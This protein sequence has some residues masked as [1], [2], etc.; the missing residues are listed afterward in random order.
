MNIGVIFR[1]TVT[2]ESGILAQLH[3]CQS[4]KRQVRRF[5]QVPISASVQYNKVST[6]YELT[7]SFNLVI[8]LSFLEQLSPLPQ[9][10]Q[11]QCRFSY[12]MVPSHSMTDLFLLYPLPYLP[13]A[14][15][16][17]HFL[18]PPKKTGSLKKTSLMKRHMATATHADHIK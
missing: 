15:P 8:Q 9:Y 2:V 12:Y 14:L 11:C 6:T 5:F 16:L 17:C 1:V 4:L 18:M 13:Q 10:T 7:L 3:P